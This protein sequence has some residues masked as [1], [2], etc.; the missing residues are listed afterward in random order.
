MRFTMKSFNR[1][2]RTSKR[3]LAVFLDFSEEVR[4]TMLKK[5]EIDNVIIKRLCDVLFIDIFLFFNYVIKLSS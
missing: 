2:K 4:L 1:K 3:N 5:T